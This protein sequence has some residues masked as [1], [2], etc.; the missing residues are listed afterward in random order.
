MNLKIVFSRNE[1]ETLKNLGFR[2][3]ESGPCESVKGYYLYCRGR[4]DHDSTYPNLSIS[5]PAGYLDKL[6]AKCGV[7]VPA[8]KYVKDYPGEMGARGQYYAPV[9]G[10]AYR[11]YVPA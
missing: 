10:E 6:A 1:C 3:I 9:S 2:D 11:F 8:T 5:Y 4:Y 7:K